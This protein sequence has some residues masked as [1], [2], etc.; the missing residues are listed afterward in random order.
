MPKTADRRR[1]ST[2]AKTASKKEGMAMSNEG[3]SQP[4]KRTTKITRGVVRKLQTKQFESIDIID[5]FETDIEWRTDE[6]LEAQVQEET[7]KLVKRFKDFHDSLLGAL[8]LSHKKAFLVDRE[9]NQFSVGDPKGDLD[10]FE[11]V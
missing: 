3:Q 5:R 4:P 8:M 10:L 6:E 11:T 7:D 1:R 2:R 9:G